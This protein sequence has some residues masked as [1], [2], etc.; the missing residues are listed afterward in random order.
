MAPADDI[1]W[2]REGAKLHY[3]VCPDLCEGNVGITP[4]LSGT[5]LALTQDN[6]PVKTGLQ[7]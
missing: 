5:S 1:P 6:V 2:G 3:H 4:S 7:T